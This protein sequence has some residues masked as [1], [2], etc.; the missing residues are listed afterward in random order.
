MLFNYLESTAET[1][2]AGSTR[3][4][5]QCKNTLSPIFKL[6]CFFRWP[7]PPSCEKNPKSTRKHGGSKKKKVSANLSAGS[8]IFVQLMITP[9]KIKYTY[10]IV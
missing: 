1:G 7:R 10:C 2:P 9:N 5:V 3:Y 8:I 6:G 4:V